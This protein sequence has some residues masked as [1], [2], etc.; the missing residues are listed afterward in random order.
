MPPTDATHLAFLQAMVP[1][2]TLNKGQR[3]A[4]VAV[5]R[6]YPFGTFALRLGKVSVL[7]ANGR[8]YR[9]H[10][11]VGPNDDVAA[12]TGKRP[13]IELRFHENALGRA[14]FTAA[15]EG[16]WFKPDGGGIVRW[17]IKHLTVSLVCPENYVIDKAYSKPVRVW[18]A[19]NINQFRQHIHHH[20]EPNFTKRKPTPP[21]RPQPA[22]PASAAIDAPQ[23]PERATVGQEQPRTK[24]GGE[25]YRKMVN[26]IDAIDG[27]ARRIS[28]VNRR[29]RSARA[30]A[31]VLV[32]SGG[33]CENPECTS[34]AFVEKNRNN[35][36]IL[37][38]DHVHD[39]ALGGPD[40]PANMIALCPNCHAVKTHGLRAE[41]LRDLLTQVVRERHAAAWNR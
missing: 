11:S 12:V 22:H 18:T 37:E 6:R 26:E 13:C 40:H 36:P 3:V 10:I 30:R 38:I 5:I 41:K 33:R 24:S 1:G 25:Q 35:D 29:Q 2:Y 27:P 31:A 19:T 14:A 4:R 15:R 9:P 8:S 28:T 20:L 17:N 16:G 34:P 23:A 7:T 21:A 39:L 32:R